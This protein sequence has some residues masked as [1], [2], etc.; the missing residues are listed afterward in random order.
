M[1]FIQSIFHNSNIWNVFWMNQVQMGQNVVESGYVGRGWQV[2][3]GLKS[4]LEF[5]SLSVLVLHETL[6]VPVL[7]YISD[8][9]LW[10]GI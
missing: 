1:G 8:T 10:K 5:C 7:T 3:L 4:M 9:M 6:L 2:P